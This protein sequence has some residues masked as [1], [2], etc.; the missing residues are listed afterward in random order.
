MEKLSGELA[1]GGVV[2]IEERKQFGEQ[3]SSVCTMDHPV[4]AWALSK[5]NQ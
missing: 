4:A 2:C 5:G 3:S 1:V